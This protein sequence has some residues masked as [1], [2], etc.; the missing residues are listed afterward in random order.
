LQFFTFFADA[1]KRSVISVG[2]LAPNKPL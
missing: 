1:E 2:N